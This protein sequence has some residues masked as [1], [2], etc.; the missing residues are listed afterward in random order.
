LIIKNISIPIISTIGKFQND[1]SHLANIM[2]LRTIFVRI[3]EGKGVKYYREDR[4]NRWVVESIRL[5]DVFS[6]F[7]L[8]AQIDLLK[9]NQI[10]FLG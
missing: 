4:I 3:G 10:V 8:S 5:N 6:Y 1:L 9:D 2:P 7:G